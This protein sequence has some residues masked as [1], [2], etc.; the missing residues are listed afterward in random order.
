MLCACSDDSKENL[1]PDALGS[2][3]EDSDDEDI[4]YSDA[5][6]SCQILSASSCWCSKD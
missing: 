6:K 1:P 3:A 4:Q 5:R 2:L